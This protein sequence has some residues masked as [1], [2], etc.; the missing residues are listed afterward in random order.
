MSLAP[1]EAG[2]DPCRFVVTGSQPQQQPLLSIPLRLSDRPLVVQDQRVEQGQPI[3][4][5]FREQDVVEVPNSAAIISLRPGDIL[6]RLPAR[7][8]GRRGQRPPE[9]ALG[10]RLI[11][12]GRDGISRLAA[13]RVEDIVVAPAA[14]VLESLTPGRLDLRVDGLGIEGRVGWG[15]AATGRIV[16]A[17]PGPDAEVRASAIDVAAAGAI[18]VVGARIDVEAVSRARAIGVAAIVTGGILGRDLRQLDESESRQQAALHAAAPFGLVALGG[19]GRAAIPVHIWDLLVAAAGRGAGI[20]PSSRWLVSDVDPAP[21]LDAMHRPPGT[22]RVA[23]GAHR[24]TEG[25]LVGLAGQRRWPGGIYAPGAFVEVAAEGGRT[26][27]LC[28]PLW[29]LE[30]LG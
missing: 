23:A 14:G 24:E 7:A 6:E 15:R 19:Y 1:S 9:S 2:R 20:L 5:R 21:L 3:V 28:L 29:A 17:V 30:R 18:L 4:E 8:R 11:E 13:G 10:A 25:R 12:H 26:E 16:I 27:R 22:V